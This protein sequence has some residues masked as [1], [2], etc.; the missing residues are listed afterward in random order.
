MRPSPWHESERTPPHTYRF[1]KPGKET[2]NEASRTTAMAALQPAF[3]AGGTS[4]GSC[5]ARG[6]DVSICTGCAWGLLTKWARGV[7]L[8]L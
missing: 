7:F 4:G 8:A 2:E 5:S 3:S 1:T 6:L